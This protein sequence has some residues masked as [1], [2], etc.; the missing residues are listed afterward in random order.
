[1][2]IELVFANIV[3]APLCA[4]AIDDDCIYKGPVPPSITCDLEVR[5]GPHVL[6]IEHYDKQPTDT[7]VN[8][9]GIIIRDR[10][11]ELSGVKIDGYDIAELIWQSEFISVDGQCYP[12]C[13]YF[14]PNGRFILR[15]ESPSLKWILQTRHERDQNDPTWQ[16]DLEMYLAACRRLQQISQPFQ[17]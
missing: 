16:Q 14:G 6:Y 3:D 7:V 1:M 17:N 2:K 11:F 9:Q 10:G 4:V 13:L 12:S 15:F 5:P 8:D